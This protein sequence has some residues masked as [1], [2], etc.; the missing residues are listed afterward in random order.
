MSNIDIIP[1]IT[2]K[3]I[4]YKSIERDIALPLS[5]KKTG[6]NCPLP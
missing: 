2:L 6:T 3:E 4:S 5:Y 1:N